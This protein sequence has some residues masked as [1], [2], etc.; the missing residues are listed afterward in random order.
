MS[1]V[2]GYVTLFFGEPTK[3]YNVCLIRFK[4]FIGLFLVN[5]RLLKFKMVVIIVVTMVVIA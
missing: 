1:G 2:G 5:D 3:I 4:P